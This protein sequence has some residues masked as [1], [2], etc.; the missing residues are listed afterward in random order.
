MID[1]SYDEKYDSLDTPSASYTDRI[2][3]PRTL[4]D[5]V[6]FMKLGNQIKENLVK[7]TERETTLFL[8]SVLRRIIDERTEAQILDRGT[9]F[10]IY[11]EV[12]EQAEKEG[13]T[14]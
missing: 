4:D 8:L 2:D 5:Y 11:N 1:S 9:G 3:D 14:G 6:T 13:L 7:Q 10:F 12:R